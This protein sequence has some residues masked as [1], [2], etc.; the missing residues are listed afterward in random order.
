MYPEYDYI[1]TVDIERKYFRIEKPGKRVQEDPN[2]T[3]TFG[4][5]N[6]DAGLRR[7]NKILNEAEKRQ[8]KLRAS[9]NLHDPPEATNFP[10]WRLLIDMFINQCVVLEESKKS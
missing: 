2:E 6:F 7:M 3:Y 4:T 1:I 8:S 10:A 5:P 9:F